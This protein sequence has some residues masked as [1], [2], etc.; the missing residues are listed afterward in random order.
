MHSKQHRVLVVDDHPLSR[1]ALLLSMQLRG[2]V[3]HGV[4]SPD[5]ALAAIEEFRPD[6]VLLEWTFRDPR[7]HGLGLARKL[8]A[9]SLELGQ[10]LSV[11]IV[12][13]ADQPTDFREREGV[14]AYFT[15]PV[16]S[17]VLAAAVAEI[18][19]RWLHADEHATDDATSREE[20]SS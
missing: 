11:I 19:G 14:E 1:S 8:R 4:A 12:S 9:R 2:Y 17:H 3:C 15:K 20:L 18:S 6:V 10:Q 5:E 13:S 7:H 16:A